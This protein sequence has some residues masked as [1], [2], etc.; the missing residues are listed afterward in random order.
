MRAVQKVERSPSMVY[1]RP[2][3]LTPRPTAPVKT[4]RLSL[5]RTTAVLS[6]GAARPVSVGRLSNKLLKTAVE[7][8]S[9]V[10]RSYTLNYHV[11]SVMVKDYYLTKADCSFPLWSPRD[12]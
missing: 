12:C 7:L 6:A 4:T 3:D 11:S 5:H 9:R 1:T 8:V 10:V 2:N